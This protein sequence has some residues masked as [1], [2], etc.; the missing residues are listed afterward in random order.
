M[1]ERMLKLPVNFVKILISSK[2]TASVL[3]K[4]LIISRSSSAVVNPSFI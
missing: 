4:Q 2:R 1:H 3:R